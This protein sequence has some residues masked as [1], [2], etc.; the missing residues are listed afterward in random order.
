M[1]PRV[2]TAKSSS[3]GHGTS[4][5][6]SSEHWIN[7]LMVI[8]LMMVYTIATN[9][10]PAG[11]AKAVRAGSRAVLTALQT[12]EREHGLLLPR[13]RFVERRSPLQLRISKR[14]QPSCRRPTPTNP[15]PTSTLIHHQRPLLRKHSPLLRIESRDM[16]SIRFSD[17]SS[18]HRRSSRDPTAN[19]SAKTKK[20][21]SSSP[22]T[23]T[24]RSTPTTGA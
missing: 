1:D 10:A 7:S 17:L 2:S 6:A 18:P 23:W 24:P 22:P 21:R 14:N 9:A 4:S 11:T 16:R 13:S 3:L 5:D 8:V 12:G 20:D 19:S 15:G